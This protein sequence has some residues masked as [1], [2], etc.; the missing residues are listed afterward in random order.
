MCCSTYYYYCVKA[1]QVVGTVIECGLKYQ[2]VMQDFIMNISCP[3][4]FIVFSLDRTCVPNREYCQQKTKK[5]LLI[6]GGVNYTDVLFWS[7]APDPLFDCW[8]VFQIQHGCLDSTLFWGH[9]IELPNAV[10]HLFL[11]SSDFVLLLVCN[12]SPE[13]GN[14]SNWCLMV[15]NFLIIQ[16]PLFQFQFSSSREI[17]VPA[18]F[19][20]KEEKKIP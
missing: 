2:A 6:N 18:S 14:S 7:S 5:V 8:A 19:S 12:Q 9:W 4:S 15:S 1:L 10:Q 13:L 17:N 11:W 16:L 3:P 20:Q